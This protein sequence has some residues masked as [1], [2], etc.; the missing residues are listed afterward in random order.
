MQPA[1]P[2]IAPRKS[3]VHPIAQWIWITPAL[4]LHPGS[5]KGALGWCH[6]STALA[7]CLHGPRASLLSLAV[8]V[9]GTQLFS[10]QNAC[11]PLSCAGP[12]TWLFPGACD[13]GQQQGTE[14]PCMAKGNPSSPAILLLPCPWGSRGQDPQ[15]DQGRK[16]GKDLPLPPQV[17]LEQRIKG[18]TWS[19]Q[20]WQRT[21]TTTRKAETSQGRQPSLSQGSPALLKSRS[22]LEPL[23]CLLMGGSMTAPWRC[24][25]QRRACWDTMQSCR[26]G[27]H[28]HS[29]AGPR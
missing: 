4:W 12:G 14:G 9:L 20:G 2:G 6:L 26:V 1:G 21:Q 17:L 28:R 16:E 10:T 18:L 11:M 19:P 15:R 29:G 23:C 25:C 3:H 27:P 22:T 8:P 13:R 7:L 24:H 5:S